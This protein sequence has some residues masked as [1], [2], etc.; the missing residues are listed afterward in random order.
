M[1]IDGRLGLQLAYA[2]EY[3]YLQFRRICELIALGCLM[4]HGDLDHARSENARRIW[5]A[6]KIMRL[7]GELH[8]HFFPQ[9]ATVTSEGGGHHIEANKVPN[10]LTLKGL[11]DLYHECGDVL[12]RGTIRS[13]ELEA[14]FRQSDMDRVNDWHTKIVNLMNTHIIAR[15]SGDSLYLVHVLS[16][17]GGPECLVMNF[18]T[19]GAATM[20]IDRFT[21]TPNDPTAEP[22]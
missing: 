22:L 14:P 15:A 9:P 21:V 13:F 1:A 16:P 5:N 7:L 20:Q 18:D 12:H 2:R 8:P 6:D 4:L 11:Q 17:S 10:A 3:S 19:T